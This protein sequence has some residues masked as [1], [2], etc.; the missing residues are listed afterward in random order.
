MRAG[1]PGSAAHCHLPYSLTAAVLVATQ[2]MTSALA[3]RTASAWGYASVT[4]AHSLLPP[5]SLSK[6]QWTSA[7]LASPSSIR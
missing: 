6:P 2:R 1:L 7:P 4:C 5:A 3:W